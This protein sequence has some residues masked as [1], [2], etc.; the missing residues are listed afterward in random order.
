MPYIYDEDEIDFPQPPLSLLSGGA[1]ATPGN[2]KSGL[3]YLRS[4]IGDRL[5][6]QISTSTNR[7][8]ASHDILDALLLKLITKNSTSRIR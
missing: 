6:F 3:Y 7:K 5:G 4:Y 2:E 1:E 8:V